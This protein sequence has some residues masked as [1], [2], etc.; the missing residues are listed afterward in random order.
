MLAHQFDDPAQQKE[1]ATLGM[2]A[3]LATEV[4]FFGGA[5]TAFVVYRSFYAHAFA[6]AAREHMHIAAG[7]I[8]TAVLLTSSLTVALSVYFAS[9]GQK[10]PLVYMLLATIALAVIFLGIKA[11]EY[12]SEYHEHLVPGLNFE[13]PPHHHEH[14]EHLTANP[15]NVE[16][17]FCFYFILTGIHALHMIVGLG[18]FTWLTIK[19]SRGRFSAEYYN[20]VEVCGLYWHF[21]DLVWIFLF[22]LLYLLH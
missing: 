5:L 15:K 14:P 4:M 8:N 10:K 16:L 11:Y 1:A 13:Y 22:P 2:W 6:Q 3:F 9:H 12:T 18:L 19:A 17:F 7:T 20:P 21:V